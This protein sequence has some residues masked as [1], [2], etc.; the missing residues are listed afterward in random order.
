MSGGE[1]G[2]VPPPLGSIDAIRAAVGL[3]RGRV[4]VSKR[5]PAE[6]LTFDDVVA[7]V[8]APARRGELGAEAALVAVVDALANLAMVLVRLVE[9]PEGAHFGDALLDAILSGQE[10]LA[11]VAEL[12]RMG[13]DDVPL[14]MVD[15]D[16]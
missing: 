2:Q 13:D 3:V 10:T 8:P 7:A 6:P 12:R 16:G 4:A 14:W 11:G 9:C 5:E 15:G 1:C